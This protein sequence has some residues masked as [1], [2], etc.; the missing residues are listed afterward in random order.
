MEEECDC[1][2]CGKCREQLEHQKRIENTRGWGCDYWS[3]DEK[4]EGDE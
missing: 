1:G 4:G 3:D 2:Y